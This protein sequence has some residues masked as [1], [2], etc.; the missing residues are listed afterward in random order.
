MGRTKQEA[1]ETYAVRQKKKTKND[2]EN[3][4]LNDSSSSWTEENC[5]Q[6]PTYNVWREGRSKETFK[7]FGLY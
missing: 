2:D 3:Y 1:H 7:M 6:L 5:L 4:Y